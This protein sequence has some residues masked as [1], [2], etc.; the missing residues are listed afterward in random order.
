MVSSTEKMRKFIFEKSTLNE[1]VNLIGE[2]FEGV[3]VETVI[4]GGV[5]GKKV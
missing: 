5:K 2:S 4:I 1:I 3:N